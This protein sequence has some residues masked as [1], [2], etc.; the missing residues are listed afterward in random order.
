MH[1][2]WRLST[3]GQISVDVAEL[4]ESPPSLVSSSQLAGFFSIVI[5]RNQP[6][7]HIII[8]HGRKNA[9]LLRIVSVRQRPPL[10]SH[11]G[12]RKPAFARYKQQLFACC[13]HL[14]TDKGCRQ[15]ATIGHLWL[16][17]SRPR[18]VGVCKRC[19][20]LCPLSVL[21]NPSACSQQIPLYFKHAS[22]DGGSIWH[23]E[24]QISKKPRRHYCL[25]QRAYPA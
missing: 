1:A 13:S 19:S 8:V 6:W 16:E 17:S 23:G 2:A 22:G 10:A 18:P 14:T 24:W 20:L 25:S 4:R 9:V 5:V 3:T 12:Y 15:A 7:R 11:E 21:R